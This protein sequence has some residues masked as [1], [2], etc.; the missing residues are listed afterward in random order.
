MIL[1]VIIALLK[2]N[3]V[4]IEAFESHKVPSIAYTFTNLTSD[5]VKRQ[6]RLEL[7]IIEKDYL[8]ALQK[9]E[10]LKEILLTLGDDRLQD[11]IL[12]VEL[13]G[14]GT[15]RDHTTKCIHIKQIYILKSKERY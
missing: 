13:N 15:L 2:A 12:S 3:N 9:S 14:G 11:D 8:K 5:K 1:E 6:D 10:Q 4:Q 7:T